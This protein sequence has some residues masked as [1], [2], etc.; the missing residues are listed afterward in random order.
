L[1]QGSDVEAAHAANGRFAVAGG[2][3]WIVSGGRDRGTGALYRLDPS[4]GSPESVLSLAVSRGN[5]AT[6][7]DSPGPSVFLDASGNTVW[8]AE[9]PNTVVGIAAATGRIVRTLAAEG[10]MWTEVEVAD[11]GVRVANDAAGSVWRFDAQ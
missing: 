4:G 11:D 10:G 2:Y 8:V 5:G 7:K 3:V 9:A 6:G 1:P